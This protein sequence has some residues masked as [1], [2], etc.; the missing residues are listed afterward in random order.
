MEKLPSGS[1]KMKSVEI[2]GKNV[3]FFGLAKSSLLI[4]KLNILLG[5]LQSCGQ[6]ST[7]LQGESSFGLGI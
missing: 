1:C 4:G 6:L 7:E 2:V 3:T 5:R